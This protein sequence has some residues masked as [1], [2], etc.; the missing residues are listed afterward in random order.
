MLYLIGGLVLLVVA[1]AW[2]LSG[3]PVLGT[4]L[5]D[6]AGHALVAMV[7]GALLE[8]GRRPLGTWWKQGRYAVR[9][10]WR[11]CRR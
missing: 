3:A 11:R 7:A 5:V 6:E 8:R 1:A 2:S 4:L 9:V 10:W